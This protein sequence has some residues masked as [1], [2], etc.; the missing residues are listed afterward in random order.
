MNFP[1]L[2]VLTVVAVFLASPPARAYPDFIGY[3]YTSCVTCHVNPQGAGP[4]NDYGRAV[5]AG[6]ISS[7][8]LFADTTTD[9]DLANASGFLGKKELPWW[10]RPAFKYRGLWVNS[11]PGSSENR[12]NFY[13]MQEE[14]DLSLALDKEQKFL[15]EL[16]LSRYGGQDGVPEVWLS[17]EHYLRMQF[18]KSWWISVGMLDK[19]FGIRLI[20]H[21]VYALQRAGLGQYNNPQSTLAHGVVIQYNQQDYEITAN[22]FVGN[23]F[24][25]TSEEEQVKQKGASLMA[26]YNLAEKSRIGL[27]VLSSDSETTTLERLALHHKLGLSAGSAILSEV[28]IHRDKAKTS[29]ATNTG[30]F[31]FIQTLLRM[32]RG[33]NFLSMAEYYQNQTSASGATTTAPNLFRWGLGFLIFPLPRIETRLTAQSTRTWAQDRGVK[34]SWALLAQVHLSL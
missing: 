2:L 31:G 23:L 21:T 11:N 7:R 17:R 5:F 30:Y 34:D 24:E 9:D 27:S 25:K 10:L 18:A 19:V 26:E 20:D 15:L 13:I 33:Y 28:G 4:L 32:K 12:K 29:D 8:G 14:F 3:G 6:E 1:S 16:G 22:V